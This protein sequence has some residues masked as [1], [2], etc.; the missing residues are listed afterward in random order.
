[1]AFSDEHVLRMKIG[2]EGSTFS[3]WCKQVSI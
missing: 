1:M 3:A 2:R